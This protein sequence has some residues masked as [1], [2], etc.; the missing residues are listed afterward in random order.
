MLGC[1][2][3][4]YV[5][6]W[7]YS[8]EMQKP[9]ES[10]KFSTILITTTQ[11]I[12]QRTSI[13]PFHLILLITPNCNFQMLIFTE[14]VVYILPKFNGNSFL[15]SDCSKAARSVIHLPAHLLNTV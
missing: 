6:V 5:K 3:Y 13:N 8:I 12:A 4:N 9:M 1:Q 15:I 10:D 2:G 14:Y 7:A 11:L